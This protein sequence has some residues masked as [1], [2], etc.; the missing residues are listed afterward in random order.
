M[1]VISVSPAARLL[2]SSE[3]VVTDDPFDHPR[4]RLHLRTDIERG[5]TFDLDPDAFRFL[6][7]TLRS[8]LSSY[9]AAERRAADR[10]PPF[11]R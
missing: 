11:P 3:M 6:V 7:H 8:V 10:F 9:R 4:L 2:V 1:H 5:V